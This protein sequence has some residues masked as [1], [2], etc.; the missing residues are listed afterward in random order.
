M[1]KRKPTV[2]KVTISLPTD[3]VLAVKEALL[4]KCG[5]F[6]SCIRHLV[7]DSLARKRK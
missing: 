5:N 2:S 6:S 1:T 3:M 4:L 7:I